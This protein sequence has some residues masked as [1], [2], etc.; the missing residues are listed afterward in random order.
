MNSLCDLRNI[1][2]LSEPWF[3]HLES[4]NDEDRL[5]HGAVGKDF[6]LPTKGLAQILAQVETDPSERLSDLFKGHTTGI[7]APVFLCT[8][9]KN[10]CTQPVHYA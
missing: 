4:G 2:T 10:K 1:L 9:S 3:S 7:R 6:A 5:P 8:F